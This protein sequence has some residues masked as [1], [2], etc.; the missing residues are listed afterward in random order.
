M[1]LRVEYNKT[2][3]EF[4]YDTIKIVDTNKVQLLIH[5]RERINGLTKVEFPDQEQFI[6][7][8]TKDEKQISYEVELGKEYKITITTEDGN[9]EEKIIKIDNYYY[10]IT[11][12]QGNK[13]IIDNNATK[14]AYNKEYQANIMA[15][16][17]YVITGLTVTMGGQTITTSGNN[18][19]DVATGK[20]FIEKVIGDI[21]ITVISKKLEI[22][23][24]TIAIGTSS[25]AS[26]TSSVDD[27][28]KIKGTPLYIN[29]IANL[30][31]T[32]CTATLKED[33]TKAVPY[34]VTKNGKY[35]FIV[36][37][38][39][40]G[41]TISEEK[42]VDVKKYQSA[43]ELVQYNAGDWTET[44]IQSLQ[45]ANLYN[46]NASKIA[47][48]TEGLN[49]TFGGFTYKE[50]K[51]NE[52][53]ISNGTVITS[54]NQSVAPQN[55]YGKPKY[56]GWQL[57]ETEKKQDEKGNI[58]K[59]EDG[60]DRIYVKKIIHTGSTENFTYKARNYSYD[61]RRVEYILSS[62]LRY[63]EYNTYNPRSWQMYVDNS[64]K[65][66]IEDTT[67]KDGKKIKDIHVITYDEAKA[68]TENS[69]D[70]NGIRKTGSGYWLGTATDGDASVRLVNSKGEFSYGYNGLC[71][72]IRL[73]VSMKSGVYIKS[74]DGIEG[75]PYI[76]GIE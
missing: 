15:E 72:G 58:I 11:K 44:E 24:T 67:D 60:T 32:I 73:V 38:T 28:S 27:N 22:Q 9:K 16:E 30:E 25:S 17:N 8:G 6:A 31:G 34:E 74:G 43:A 59:N 40:N 18:I 33:N 56:E 54:R 53:Y 14:V 48:T 36:T 76:L 5:V 42:E 62:G 68:I 69:S 1:N 20:I 51:T 21:E 64:Q 26:N 10:K 12:K 2:N 61:N 4:S 63:T 37:G 13:V 47:S 70:K 41:K 65:D 19:V 3:I 75:N 39:Y 66:L 46:I 57:L 71:L 55:D 52:T 23:Y 35:V 49:F 7:N 45:T 50:D 29:I